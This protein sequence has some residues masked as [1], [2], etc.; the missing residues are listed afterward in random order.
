MVEN[1]N[2]QRARYMGKRGNC[3]WS[4]VVGAASQVRGGGVEADEALE[5]AGSPGPLS[6]PAGAK[7]KIA[8]I[9]KIPHPHC[10][11][12]NIKM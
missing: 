9:V 6:H 1:Y 12:Q 3:A 7:R 10:M 2:Y 11:R 5:A 4:S 8:K